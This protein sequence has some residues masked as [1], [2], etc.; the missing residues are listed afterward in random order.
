ML[1]NASPFSPQ[2]QLLPPLS[3]L[4]ADHRA[5]MDRWQLDFLPIRFHQFS[6]LLLQLCLHQ[7]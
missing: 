4:G 6:N 1:P 7:L 3:L 5:W 2:E